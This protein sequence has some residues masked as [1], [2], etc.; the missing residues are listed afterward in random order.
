MLRSPPAPLPYLTPC[1]PRP[2]AS[3]SPSEERA[4]H[5]IR[6]LTTAPNDESARRLGT[7]TR[8]PPHSS[9]A[10]SPQVA[11]AGAMARVYVGNLDAR[12]N[13]DELADECSRY[14]KLSDVWIARNPPGFAFVTFEDDRDAEDCVRGMNDTKIGGQRVKCEMARNR[15]GGMAGPQGARGG[16]GRGGGRDAYGGADDRD[17]DRERERVR[18]PPRYAREEE[19]RRPKK[20][21]SDSDL[22]DRRKSR[23]PRRE[24]SSDEDRHARKK[25]P[26]R[27]ESE[28]DDERRSR[29]KKSRKYSDEEEEPKRKKKPFE[30][31]EEE[32]K[33]K[34]SKRYSDE[35]SPR[36]KRGSDDDRD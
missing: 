35:D 2:P 21:D 5:S 6:F 33:K 13:K 19:R 29:K 31:E 7:P 11:P 30:E 25:K 9:R 16:G 8:S 26:K 23:K 12:T 32:S 15:G 10:P 14:G 1:S 27:E 36:N 28:S 24:E 20:Y 4:L 17:R 22:D 34:K 3:L 18:S